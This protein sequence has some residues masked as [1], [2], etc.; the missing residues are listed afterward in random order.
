[1]HETERFGVQGLAWTRLKTVLYELCV[2]GC[3]YSPQNFVA[4]ISGVVKKRMAYML[5]VYAD[6]VCAPCFQLAFND[7]YMRKI[8]YYFVVCDG[9]FAIVAFRKYRH[10]QPVFQASSYIPFYCAAIFF[11]LPPNDCY[12]LA[13]RCFVEK[14]F[15]EICFCVGRFCDDQQPRRVF[16]DAVNQ[17]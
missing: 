17:A 13:V 14:L 3:R 5:H 1:M 8:F 9:V 15:P 11:E 6:L 10:L 16:V 4:A 12:V 2:F 7:S